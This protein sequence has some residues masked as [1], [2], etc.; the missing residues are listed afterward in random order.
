MLRTPSSLRVQDRD[1]S[2]PLASVS[3]SR[4]GSSSSVTGRRASSPA[5]ASGSVSSAGLASGSSP[6]SFSSAGSVTTGSSAGSAGSVIFPGSSPSAGSVGSAGSLPSAG[7]V[8]GPA[9]SAGSVI[10]A[11][12][13]AGSS[14]SSISSAGAVVS[15]TEAAL[16]ATPVGDTARVSAASGK[17]T[18]CSG[19]AAEIVIAPSAS[20]VQV[21]PSPYETCAAGAS[22]PA[23]GA[24]H[25]ACA[26]PANMAIESRHADHCFHA[27]PFIS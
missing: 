17:P 22:P 18:L 9:G 23:T 5:K 24:A 1:P 15:A 19:S 6:G 25:T 4:S 16:C 12:S 13:L 20:V 27:R 2:V 14:G 26:L 3:V 10:S 21:M 8:V 7:S 11:G